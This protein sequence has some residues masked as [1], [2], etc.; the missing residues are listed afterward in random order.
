[1]VGKLK[2]VLLR[3][4]WKHEA[5]DFTAWLQENIEVLN[6]MLD[7]NLTEVERERAAGSFNVDLVAEDDMGNTVIIENQLE[8]SNH[9]HL[10]KLITYLTAREA[11]TAIWIVAEP[12]PEHINAVAWLNESKLASFYLLKLEAV[13]IDDSS[14]APLLTLIVGPSE[15]AREVGEAKKEMAERYSIRKKFWSE[16]LNQSKT[17]TKLHTNI[18]PSEHGWIS[19]GAGKSGLG[20][21]YATTK[22]Q[23][24]VELYI[25]RGKNAEEENKKIYDALY[26]DK[27]HIEKLFGSKLEWNRLDG[28]RASRI[29]KTIEGGY[30]TAEARWKEIHNSMIANMI[31]LEKAIKPSIDKLKV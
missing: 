14:P 8:K 10:G 18:S 20:F 5:R 7:L 27:E 28:K 12:R 30:R 1:M 23:S 26:A 19:T 6:E 29:R 31:N 25:D 24:Y 3:D 15:E 21:N 16:L 22:D 17:R 2:R 9:D 4:V 13:C 11:K